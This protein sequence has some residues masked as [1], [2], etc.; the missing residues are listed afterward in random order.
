MKRRALSCAL[1]GLM[2]AAVALL[3]APAPARLGASRG[4]DRA[5]AD[6]VA[7]VVG[8]GPRSTAADLAQLVAGVAAGTAPGADARHAPLRR[9]RHSASS[10]AVSAAVIAVTR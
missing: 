6:R 9:R 7:A 10:A 8:I 1:A 5:L 2:A 3:T 4:G